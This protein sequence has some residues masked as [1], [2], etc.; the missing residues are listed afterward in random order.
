MIFAP[1]HWNIVD[2][3]YA[4]TGRVISYLE[5]GKTLTCYYQE[6]PIDPLDIDVGFTCYNIVEG[7]ALK[8]LLIELPY[9]QGS[10][11]YVDWFTGCRIIVETNDISLFESNKI[12]YKETKHYYKP[13]DAKYYD[14]LMGA[15]FF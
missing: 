10:V 9:V 7:I 5:V 4:I 2:N 11:D 6:K 8:I 15:Y 13:D 3:Q 12:P 14:Y 1:D